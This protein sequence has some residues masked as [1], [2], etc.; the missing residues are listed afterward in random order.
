VDADRIAPLLVDLVTWRDYRKRTKIGET[1]AVIAGESL[2]L[3]RAA[4]ICLSEL[5]GGTQFG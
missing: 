1:I 2:L 5:S 4:S 3:E